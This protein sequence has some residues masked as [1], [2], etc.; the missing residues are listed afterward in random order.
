MKKPMTFVFEGEE[1]TVSQIHALIPAYSRPAIQDHC[2]QGRLTRQAILTHNSAAKKSAQ[3]RK[4]SAKSRMTY[5]N[6]LGPAKP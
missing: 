3:S 5:N 6:G 1:M 4:A 2:E